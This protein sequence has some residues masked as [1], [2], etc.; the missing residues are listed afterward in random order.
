MIKVNR[1]FQVRHSLGQLDLT[2]VE[3]DYTVHKSEVDGCGFSGCLLK[4]KNFSK[5]CNHLTRNTLIQTVYVF[6]IFPKKTLGFTPMS[7]H[8][9]LLTICGSPLCGKT[10][11]HFLEFYFNMCNAYF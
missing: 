1:H 3:K 8:K 2:L 5:F 9:Y 6:L 11:Y 4:L 7:L 10:L